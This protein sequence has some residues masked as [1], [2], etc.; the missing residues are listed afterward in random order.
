MNATSNSPQDTATLPAPSNYQ[1]TEPEETPSPTDTTPSSMR[2]QERS[3]ADLEQN[4]TLLNNAAAP[5]WRPSTTE[6][7]VMVTLAIIS[8][9]VSLDATVIVTALSTIVQALNATSTQ[10]FWIGTSYLLVVAVTMPFT[11]SISDIVGRP[12]TLFTVLLS[13]TVGTVLCATAHSIGIM[14]VGRCLQGVG[15]GGVIIL[16]LVV[17]S[18]IVPLRFRPQYVGVLQGAWALGSV[19]GPIVGGAFASP[20]RWRWVFYLMLPFCGVG[21]IFVP[22][23]VRLRRPQ[24]T[25]REMLGRVDWIGGVLFISSATS[26]LVA[27]SWGGTTYAWNHWRTLVPL[28][29]GLAGLVATMIWERYGAKETAFLRH[30]LFHVWSSH[31]IYFG[32]FAQGLILYAQLYYIPFFFESAKVYSPIRTGVSLLPVLLTLVPASVIVGAAITWTAK[33][34]WAITTGWILA[35]LGTGLSI[36]WNR[37]TN[38][39]AWAVEMIILGF[40]HG[41]NLNA[42][43]TASQAACKPGDEG[44]A[45]GMYAFLRSFGMA[46]GVGVGGSVFQNV[47]KAKLA[48]LGLPTDIALHAEAY[49]EV[50]KQMDPSAPQRQAAIDA[51]VAGFHGVFGFLTGLGGLALIVGLFI[52]HFE[53]NKE[54]ITEHKLVDESRI[55]WRRASQDS[56][57]GLSTADHSRMPSPERGPPVV[58]EQV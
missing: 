11:A 44:R 21:L 34:R 1:Q 48:S 27:I 20:T 40:G 42:L 57:S 26:F 35:T 14:L 49:L 25:L 24:A 47:M 56:R 8:L 4:T 33:F 29:V 2:K 32:A 52:K 17:F 45:V 53:I 16:S 9:M 7:M 41:L 12:Q 23:F 37:G 38:T 36:S 43:N 10:G 18:D 46:I 58:A 19:I 5:K 31:A 54:L 39:A 15:G 3:D 6:A 51:Y 22:L 13:F 30:S 55:S 28:L 50:L